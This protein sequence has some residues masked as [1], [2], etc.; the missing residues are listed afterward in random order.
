MAFSRHAPFL[1]GFL[2]ATMF[3]TA[4][5]FVPVPSYPALRGHA[6]TRRATAIAISASAGGEPTWAPWHQP[7]PEQ[8]PHLFYALDLWFHTQRSFFRI[9]Y[10]HV[11][12]W[13]AAV[14]EIL[15]CMCSCGTIM[16]Q[17]NEFLLNAW[18]QWVKMRPSTVMSCGVLWCMH[19]WF[20]ACCFCHKHTYACIRI[21]ICMTFLPWVSLCW[22]RHVSVHACTYVRNVAYV[23]QA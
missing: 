3:C 15:F 23:Q 5:A 17:T 7:F 8:S 16:M 2:L 19:A 22:S 14:C 11:S 18:W 4:C 9:R 21:Y 12:C 1:A 20:H 6:S 10:I 13:L